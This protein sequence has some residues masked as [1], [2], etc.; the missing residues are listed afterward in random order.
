MGKRAAI[1]GGGATGLETAL[2]LA[3]KGTISAETLHFLFRYEAESP[4]RLRELVYK[5]VHEIT[6]FETQ[7]TVGKGLGKSTKWVVMD[8]IARYGIKIITDARILKID[9]GEIRY[10]KDGQQ[11]LPFDSVI[12]ATGSKP[13]RRVA[14]LLKQTGIPFSVIGDSVNTAGIREAIHQAYLTVMENL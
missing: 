11:S 4:D 6:V 8:N 13:V 7:S 12:I 3:A 14:D 1:I 5:G 2:F 9:H 10:E